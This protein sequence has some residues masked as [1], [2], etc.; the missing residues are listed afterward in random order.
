MKISWKIKYQ[1]GK[2]ELKILEEITC[3]A[4]ESL[5]EFLFEKSGPNTKSC[6]WEAVSDYTSIDH[7]VNE[8][9]YYRKFKPNPRYAKTHPTRVKFYK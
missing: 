5:R 2:E 4:E 1:G 3:D 8:V 9:H 6:I 7:F